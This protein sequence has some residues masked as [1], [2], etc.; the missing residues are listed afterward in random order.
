MPAFLLPRTAA[1]SS[2]FI[3]RLYGGR[4]GRPARAG[5][6]GSGGGLCAAGLLRQTARRL[7]LWCVTWNWEVSK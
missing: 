6:V 7:G 5:G 3:K 2:T 1:V 4:A